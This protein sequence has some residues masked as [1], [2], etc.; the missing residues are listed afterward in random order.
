VPY[1]QKALADF[2][3]REPASYCSPAV[4][5]E[6]AVRSRERAAFLAPGE[7]GVGIGCTASLRSD[8]PKRGEHRVHVAAATESEIVV[9][10]LT[11]AKEQRDREGEESVVARLLLNTL[12][13]AFQVSFRVS[14]P[15]LAGEEVTRESHGTGLLARFLAGEV[16]AVCREPDGRLRANGAKPLLL[17]AGSFNPLHAGHLRLAKVASRLV[18]KLFAFEMSVV[19]ADKPALTEGEVRRR[20][21]QFDWLAPLWLTRSPTFT[22]KAGLF[23]GV[24]FV[25]GVDTA[26]RIVQPRFYGSEEAMRA[27]LCEMRQSGTRFLVAGR[28]VEGNF[29]PLEESKIP[30]EFIDLFTGISGEMFRMDISSTQLREAE[31]GASPPR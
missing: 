13:E 7:C 4:T 15:L 12:A 22:E 31:H 20:M 29:V 24:T 19:N 14:L 16:P 9:Q 27:A 10:S 2:L 1:A 26:V 28:L 5:R 21:E 8:R 6:L 3:G 17:L 25:V 23:P 18:G 11:L 30:E